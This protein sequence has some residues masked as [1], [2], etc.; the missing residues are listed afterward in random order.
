MC[1]CCSFVVTVLRGMFRFWLYHT[2]VSV[3]VRVA[4]SYNRTVALP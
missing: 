3:F 2:G 1:F 4:F